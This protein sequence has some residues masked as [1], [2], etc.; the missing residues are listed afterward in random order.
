MKVVE[1]IYFLDFCSLS[2]MWQ[3]NGRKFRTNDVSLLLF[4]LVCVQGTS[5]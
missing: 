4:D 2:V 1:E 5:E 3:L